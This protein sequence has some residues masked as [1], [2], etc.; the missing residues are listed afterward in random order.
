LST[1]NRTSPFSLQYHVITESDDPGR[2]YF[3][4]LGDRRGA[5]IVLRFT[6]LLAWRCVCVAERA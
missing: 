6:M 1:R 5:G 3:P 2:I 4:N